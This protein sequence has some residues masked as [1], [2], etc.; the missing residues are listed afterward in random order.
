MNSDRA[1]HDFT[2]QIST[3]DRPNS[4]AL[5]L[6]IFLLA[7]ATEKRKSEDYLGNTQPIE[8]LIRIL[9]LGQPEGLLEA[10]ERA[11]IECERA[12]AHLGYHGRSF[13]HLPLTLST[14]LLNEILFQS[15]GASDRMGEE[16]QS[17]TGDELLRY[18]IRVVRDSYLWLSDLIER[19]SDWIDLLIPE[20]DTTTQYRVVGR[21]SWISKTQ[22]REFC[23]Q[24]MV[25]RPLTE[26][27]KSGLESLWRGLDGNGWL[28]IRIAFSLARLGAKG[29]WSD[30]WAK[31]NEVIRFLR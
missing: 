5:D 20:V 28:P 3:I 26:D 30:A 9:S 4:S 29:R 8:E 15:P 18:K 31:F 24:P 27:G 17:R 19:R 6:R 7:W 13:G 2:P 16:L 21:L 12:M 22:T 11:H 1:H 23:E 10:L 25:A 14:Y